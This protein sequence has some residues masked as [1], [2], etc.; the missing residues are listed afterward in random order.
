MARD[1]QV[2]TAGITAGT[3]AENVLLE[4]G[5]LG[6]IPFSRMVFRGAFALDGSGVG[7]TADCR[8]TLPLP[9]TTVWQLDQLAISIEDTEDYT[10]N[11]LEL[12][13]APGTTAFGE[14][15]QLNFQLLPF[16]GVSPHNIGTFLNLVPGGQGRNVAGTAQA[17]S[18]GNRGPFDV[19]SFND[20]SGGADPVVWMGGGADTNLTGGTCR[21]A[22]TFLGY[23][24]EQMRRGNL[25]AGFSS[26]G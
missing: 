18:L 26:R 5:G 11:L 24:F 1:A 8:L 12:Y 22:L 3:F 17:F 19:I 14:S 7:D 15:T 25:Y 9:S 16:V 4:G 23:T 10:N 2:A 13:Y 21:F 20:S 6:I